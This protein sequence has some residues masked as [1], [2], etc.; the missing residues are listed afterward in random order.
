MEGIV[1]WEDEFSNNDNFS[2]NSITNYFRVECGGATIKYSSA[3][4]FENLIII[5]KY[6]SV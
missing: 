6:P 2:C 3:L 1:Q 4:N 5:L